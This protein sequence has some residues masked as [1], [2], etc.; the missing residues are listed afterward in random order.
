[1]TSCV[2]FLLVPGGRPWLCLD[3][4]VTQ[5]RKENSAKV[6]NRGPG[7]FASLFLSVAQSVEVGER[8]PSLLFAL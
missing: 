6:Q 2:L 4:N 7:I 5:K 3:L 1:M 8:A